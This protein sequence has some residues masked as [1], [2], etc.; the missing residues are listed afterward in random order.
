MAYTNWL[1]NAKNLEE[2][3]ELYYNLA[4]CHHPDVGGQTEIM[5][6]INAEYSLR[7]KLFKAGFN[8]ASVTP[9]QTD[10]PKPAR[11]PTSPKDN[12]HS[13]ATTEWGRLNISRDAWEAYRAVCQIRESERYPFGI[14]VKIVGG[15]VQVGG[16]A[17]YHYRESLKSLGFVWNS[18]TRY[19]FF[20]KKPST[21]QAS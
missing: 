6:Q 19:W 9:T 16:K 5:Q 11:K 14:S 3:K 18:A 20:V 4:R 10:R 12:N 1:V 2:L 21:S 8:A 15:K 17:T 7:V 13:K